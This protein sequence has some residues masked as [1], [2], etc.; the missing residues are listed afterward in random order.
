M[1]A[2]GESGRYTS[3]VSAKAASLHFPCVGLAL[4]LHRETHEVTT[5]E[6]A[7]TLGRCVCV[8]VCERERERDRGEERE[9]GREREGKRE[10]KGGERGREGGRGRW[11]KKE[12]LC[13]CV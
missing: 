10:E 4:N 11:C 12:K 13:V 2:C 5:A 6:K 1:K 3:E 8:C 7:F 9:R